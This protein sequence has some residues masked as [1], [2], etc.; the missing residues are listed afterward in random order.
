MVKVDG[1]GEGLGAGDSVRVGV[2]G[3]V[4]IAPG[5][6][7]DAVDGSGCG[8]E[9][10]G[11]G[12]APGAAGLRP[13]RQVHRGPRGH[14]DT[15][16]LLPRATVDLYPGSDRRRIDGDG[17]GLGAGHSVCVGVREGVHVAGRRERNS[18]KGTGRR[19]EG[20]RP[21]PAPG[22]PA[23]LLRTDVHRVPTFTATLEISSLR[24]R[25]VRSRSRRSRSQLATRPWQSSR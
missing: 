11:A 9:A 1:D 6:Q 15:G 25:R 2:S 8:G 19:G 5:A 16:N 3:C 10:A 24:A 14:R 22:A 23:D 4:D 13:W 20:V 12:P 7:R 21:R 18:V 17:E